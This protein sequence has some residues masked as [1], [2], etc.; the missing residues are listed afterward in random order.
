MDIFFSQQR[1][2]KESVLK[3]TFW[4]KNISNNPSQ[5]LYVTDTV[6]TGQ[7]K[8][9][10]LLLL[11]VFIRACWTPHHC[12]TGLCMKQLLMKQFQSQ[13]FYYIQNLCVCICCAPRHLRK[14]D[15]PLSKQIPILRTHSRCLFISFKDLS[16]KWKFLIR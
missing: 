10:S 13:S 9:A 15:V 1:Q 3:H 16:I 4:H 6:L 2:H 11:I 8:R 14:C 12:V 5:V 7:K